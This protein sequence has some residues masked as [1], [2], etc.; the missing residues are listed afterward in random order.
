MEELPSNIEREQNARRILL[1]EWF[2]C[3]KDAVHRTVAV[4]LNT[5]ADVFVERERE[6]HAC[7]DTAENEPILPVPVCRSRKCLFDVRPNEL[8]VVLGEK[9]LAL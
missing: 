5:F 2:Q 1:S 7:R 4:S 6:S 9:A 8:P 3:V